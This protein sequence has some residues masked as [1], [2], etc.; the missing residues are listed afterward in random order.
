MLSGLCHIVG[1]RRVEFTAKTTGEHITGWKYALVGESPKWS[2]LECGS[3]F[4]FDDRHDQPF[5]VGSE[6]F[7]VVSKKSGKIYDLEL[8][9]PRA[10]VPAVPSAPSS[11]VE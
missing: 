6:V 8:A 11:G 1:R 9:Q 5:P 3:A 10:S 4:V 7:P 2:G